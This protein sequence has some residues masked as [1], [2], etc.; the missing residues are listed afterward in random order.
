MNAFVRQDMKWKEP[1]ALTWMSV[2]L[3]DV[4]QIMTVSILLAAISV[5]VSVVSLLMKIHRNGFITNN[6][7]FNYDV[8]MKLLR[9]D[10]MSSKPSKSIV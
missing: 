3:T 4:Q 10:Q 7:M 5:I 6:V 9:N 8:I 2:F 1:S